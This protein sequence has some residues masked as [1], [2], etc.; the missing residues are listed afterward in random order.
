MAYRVRRDLLGK[1]LIIP[2]PEDE[3]VFYTVVSGNRPI[4]MGGLLVVGA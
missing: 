4:K 2:M 1:I 3:L